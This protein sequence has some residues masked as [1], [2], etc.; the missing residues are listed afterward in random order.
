MPNRL[1]NLKVSRI[2]L[3]DMGANYDPATGEGAHIL[4]WKSL[5]QDDPTQAIPEKLAKA[6]EYG[7]TGPNGEKKVPLDTEGRVRAALSMMKNGWTFRGNKLDVPASAL[8]G[9]A[10]KIRAAATKLGVTI[11]DDAKKTAEGEIDPTGA[12][13]GL[14]KRMLAGLGK[15]FNLTEDQ[16]AK[17]YDEATSY[18]EERS[19][20]DWSDVSDEVQDRI[21]SLSSALRSIFRDTSVTDKEAKLRESLDQFATDMTTNLPNWS[22]NQAVDVEKV[23]RK[24]SAERLTQLKDTRD[25]LTRVIAEAEEGTEPNP[26]AKTRKEGTMPDKPDLSGISEE[27]TKYIEG[28]ETEKTA[29]ETERDTA[30]AELE[31]TK[32][33]DP[34]EDDPVA[35]ALAD[36]N[37]SDVVKAALRSERDARLTAE[38]TARENAAVAK[39][40][41]D[42][43]ITKE[44]VAKA[45]GFT[46]PEFEAQEAG[47]ILK[48][49]SEGEP[50]T[51]EQ[52]AKVEG[53]LTAASAVIAKGEVFNVIGKTGG[54]DDS[55]T[56]APIDAA[57]RELMKSDTAL[58]YAAAVQ[59]VEQTQPD[60]V[61]K[62]YDAQREGVNA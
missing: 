57:A 12:N 8:P 55:D 50:I 34:A 10:A 37:V 13:K 23:G 17:A 51:P 39:R 1:T 11:A 16:L 2:A 54:T 58:D 38:K 40:D 46:L 4:L 18:E 56:Y 36:P 60:L 45:A 25:S 59:R 30:K 27:V 3:A 29:V 33:P 22:S 6:A 44:F 14:L 9:I 15:A 20:E 62:H 48:R 21:W 49:L 61:S 28:L 52:F 24:V 35:K 43:R 19:E 7:Y 5:D 26:T 31:K 41:R 53:W 32:T 47:A 42:E